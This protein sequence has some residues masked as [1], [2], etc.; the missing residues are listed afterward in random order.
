MCG[1]G[2]CGSGY[3]SAR[4]RESRSAGFSRRVILRAATGLALLAAGTAASRPVS[5]R[6]QDAGGTRAGRFVPEPSIDA[7]AGET[8]A[9]GFR[10][11]TA[12]YP[13]YAL[14]ASWDGAVGTWPVIEVETSVD[15]ETWSATQGLVAATTDGGRPSREGRIFT[16]LTFA[17]GATQVRFRTVDVNGTLGSVDGLSFVYID[18][19]D[20]PWEYDVTPEPAASD[21]TGGTDTLVPPKLLTREA[22]G[23]DESYRFDGNVIWPPEYQEVRHVIIHHTETPTEQD[24]LVAIRSIYYYHAVEQGWGDI[25]YN[26]LVD[27]N[28]TIYEGRYGGQDV[29]G[30]HS[31]EYAYGSSGICIIGNYQDHAESDAARAGL[32]QIAAWAARHLDPLGSEDFHEVPNLPTICAHRDVNATAC[33]GD[34]LYSDVPYIR[35]LVAQTLQSGVLDSGAPGGIAVRDR[36]IVQTDDGAALNIRAAAGTSAAIVDVLP[37]GSV[38]QVVE[39]PVSADGE[40]WYRLSWDNSTGWTVARYLIV[41]PPTA[42]DDGGF[43]FGANL[44]LNDSA[45]MRADNS[46]SGAVIAELQKGDWAYVSEGPAW[47]DGHTWYRVGTEHLGKGWVAAEYLSAAPIDLN[48]AARFTV[49][50]AVIANGDANLHP[51]PG[52]GQTVAAVLPDGTPMTV[53]VG[54]YGVTGEVWYGVYGSFGGGWIAETSIEAA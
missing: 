31:Y 13:F 21:T 12:D 49:G 44:V 38:A 48:P 22:W 40:N 54:A 2:E 4:G 37:V 23:A 20:G 36:V 19:S 26:Y 46:T 42:V 5:T 32:V 9:A 50:T 25:G 14:G 30:G 53:S 15:G 8:D 45:N 33:P 51:R 27:R 24:P 11:F 1:G 39:G 6:A 41:S 3:T 17:D 52:L 34:M 43:D 28:G 7:K 29:V 35:T 10:T 16:A 18:A 47:N